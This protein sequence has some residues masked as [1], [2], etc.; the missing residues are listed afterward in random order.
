MVKFHNT[1]NYAIAYTPVTESF[2]NFGKYGA[3]FVYIVIGLLMGFLTNYKNQIFVFAF[4]CL[5]I[6]FCRSEY[7]GFVYNYVVVLFP[8]IVSFVLNKFKIA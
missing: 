1:K 7:S 4:F 6:D 3:T 5:T 2:I 8:F